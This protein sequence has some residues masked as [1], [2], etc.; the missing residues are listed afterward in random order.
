MTSAPWPT[1]SGTRPPMS[2]V[3]VRIGKRPLAAVEAKRVE[4]AAHQQEHAVAERRAEAQQR[5]P[6]ELAQAAA[7]AGARRQ[8]EELD[9]QAVEPGLFA[10]LDQAFVD[11]L[12][13]Q[14]VRRRAA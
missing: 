7:V 11:E 12:L 13:Q 1:P 4:A 3:K 8:R 9:A 10:L 6:A 14:A 5:W 2:P